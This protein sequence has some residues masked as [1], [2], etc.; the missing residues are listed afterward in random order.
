MA[1]RPVV[2]VQG[3]DASL[4]LPEV[5]VAPIRADIVQFVH[6]NVN[7]NAR[8]AYGV[9]QRAGMGHSA[10]SWGTG[11]AVSRIPRVSGGGTSRAGQAAF[12]NMCRSGRMFN[13]NQVHRRWHRRVNTNQKRFAVASA[14]AASAL[15]ALVLA[16]G[17]KVSEVPE[18][19]LVIADTAAD[20]T[21]TSA[22][23]KLLQSLGAYDDVLK[24]KNSKQIRTGI[25]KIRNRRYTQRKGPLVVYAEGNFSFL[26]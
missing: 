4:Q 16:R 22:A 1:S 19:P 24:A 11:R 15:P 26:I 25:G 23:V 10:H 8:Q 6:T 18:F 21:K 9:F 7:K 3:S 2:S 20:T 12:G 5:F 14:V 13:P 17:H